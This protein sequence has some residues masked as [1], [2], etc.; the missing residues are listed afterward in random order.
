MPIL[1][2]H[3]RFE[4]KSP[5]GQGTG[6]RQVD[7]G[8]G[9][10]G[11][12]TEIHGEMDR[13]QP[14]MPGSSWSASVSL[15]ASHR[16][17]SAAAYIFALQNDAGPHTDARRSQGLFDTVPV[18]D[19]TSA[20]PAAITAIRHGYLLGFLYGRRE[21][22]AIMLSAP[23]NGKT[24]T[25]LLLGDLAVYPMVLLAFLES[26]LICGGLCLARSQSPC[27]F[28][29]HRETYIAR[30]V[31]GDCLC[32]AKRQQTAHREEGR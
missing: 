17:G 30:R 2:F 13:I 8:I 7:L 26:N 11:C 32:R 28:R 12:A 21:P 4:A 27:G 5:A 3:L 31:S 15:S 24:A 16:I 14:A 1:F 9:I 23:R 18:G 10:I 19:L 22:D 20:E 29:A 6:P 25:F